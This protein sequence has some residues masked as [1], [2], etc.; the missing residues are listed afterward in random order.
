LTPLA[1]EAAVVGLE[2]L[3][4]VLVQGR[5]V[6]DTGLFWSLWKES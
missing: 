3:L 4:G 6:E 1:L 5:F 2:K